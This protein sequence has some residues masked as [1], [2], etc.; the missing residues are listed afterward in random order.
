[1]TQRSR[2]GLVAAALAASVLALP[3]LAGEGMWTFDNFPIARVNKALGTSIDQA[4]L[5]RL[6]LAS[7]RIPGCS[8]SLVSG[9][10]LLLTNNH[11]VLE[12]AQNLSTPEANYVETGFSPKTRE[13]ERKCAGYTAEILTDISDVTSKVRA[14]TTGKTGQA[15]I[16][17]R[18]AEMGAIEKAECAA[19]KTTRCQVVS[20]YRGGQF[21]LYRYKRYTDVRL[22]FAPE[23]AAAAFGGDPD[24]FN[25]P[26]Y[27]VDAGFL[28]IYQ[29]G[30]PLSTPIHLKW[31]PNPPTPGEAVF[32][33][34]NP[35]STQRLLTQSQLATQRDVILPF[36]QQ[37]R[38]EF[39]GRLLRFREESAD[40]RFMSADTLDSI[41]NTY[42]RAR[43]QQRALIDTQFMAG[44]AR[45]ERELKARVAA[46]KA[47][48]KQVGDPWADIAAVQDDVAE[49]Y[50][51]WYLLESRAGGQSDLYTDAR[52]LVRAAQEREKPSQDR[53]PE[54][55]DSKLPLLEKSLLD[56]APVH[57][58]LE[59]LKLA[60]WLSKAREILTADDPRVR[61]LL[62]KESPEALAARLSKSRVADPAYRKQLWDG[63]LKAILASD[64]PLIRYV[65]AVDAQSRTVRSAWEER[66][67]GPTDRATERLASARFAIYGSSQYPD[68]TGTLRLS[69]G[70][71]EGWQENGRMIGPFTTWGGLW[72][73]ATGSDP[74]ILAKR[75]EAARGDLDPNGV[76]DM[77]VSTDTIGGS[78]GSPAV[79]ARGEIIGANFDSTFLTQRNAFGYDA[80][81]NRSVVVTTAAITQ[82]LLK[83]YGQERLVKELLGG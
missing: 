13:E 7:V 35:G 14:A 52:N 39:R 55:S 15:F 81:V 70:K 38:S 50:P 23:H 34:G 36:E 5:D 22:A 31:N 40:N 28:R 4:W 49:L 10:G 71:V 72:D 48:K 11:C 75:L 30:K 44:K 58:A 33:A 82:A 66:V 69:W 74:F 25:F 37:I 6:R 64:D 57:P 8:A 65:L 42:K 62:G 21:K 61:T 73:R 46:S 54:Y 63:G 18:D 27:A 1:M 29:D 56:D 2:L 43:G 17:A 77:T 12:C 47:L 16:K 51:A 45:E 78:S 76:L 83:A 20:L 9:E 67:Q 68:A 59:E 79:N 80:R 19:D 60:W 53:L 41:E 32:I 3:A 26:R 24:N